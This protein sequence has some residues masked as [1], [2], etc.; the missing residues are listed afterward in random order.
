MESSDGADR[1]V[2]GIRREDKNPYERRTPLTPGEVRRLIDGGIDVV[3]QP[4]PIRV[5]PDGEY[6]EAGAVVDEDLSRCDVVFG[7]KEMPLHVFREGGVYMFFSHTIKGQKYNM[8]MLKRMMDLGCTLIDYEK[9]TDDKGRRL[10]FF[11][12]HAGLAGMLDT[13]WA[14]GMRLHHMGYD[15][16]F[17]GLRQ[18]RHYHSLEEAK[19]AVRKVAEEISAKGLPGDLVPLVFGITGYGHVSTGAQEILGILPVIEMSPEDVGKIENPS[20]NHVY[21]VVFKEEHMVEPVDPS[22]PFVLQEY[23]DH[24]E[25]YRGIFPRYLEHLSVLVN[26]I[27]WDPRYP[28]LMTREVMKR[29]VSEG[30]PLPIVVGDISCD[31]D[32]S[33]EATVKP[34]DPGNPLYTFD[35]ATGQVEDGYT[36]PGM[37]VMAI[38]TLPAEIPRDASEYFGERLLPFVPSIARCRWNVPFQELDL[39]PEIKRAVI[40]HR[41]ELTDD[42]KYMER[43][44]ADQP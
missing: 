35:P 6:L 32:G 12:Y 40:L 41:G 23:Y 14:L 19:E 27:Y 2:I 4:S 29:H 39:P 26:C 36:G 30:R 24:P 22:K 13:L 31:I 7:V 10:I 44:V 15:T 43:F 11:G 1:P 20:P 3:V 38:D 5:F 37:V 25:R 18:A 34:T 17:Y 21:K 28:K 16:P 42:Y 9:V 33:I 8:P